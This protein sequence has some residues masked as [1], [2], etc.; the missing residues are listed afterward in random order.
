VDIPNASI[1]MIEGADSFGLAQLYQ[2]R[3]RVGRGEYQS[4]CF[5]MTET[6]NGINKARLKAIETAKNGFQLA[7]EDMKLRGPG[8]FLGEAQSG[9]S[10]T[11]INALKNPEMIKE[12][13]E[14]AMSIIQND[15][16]LLRSPILKQKLVE[17]EKTL[18][19]E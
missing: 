14:S 7:E 8:E 19:K 3:G 18:H 1:M 11:I 15:P 12:T 6:A 5:L 4:Y 2:F 16:L 13:R 17:F 9:F 10:D